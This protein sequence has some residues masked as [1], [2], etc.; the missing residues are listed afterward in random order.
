[1]IM[2]R[3]QT[4][5]SRAP[6]DDAPSRCDEAAFLLRRSV[7]VDSAAPEAADRWSRLS[8]RVQAYNRLEAFIA[9]VTAHGRSSQRAALLARCWPSL[10]LPLT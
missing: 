9:H 1:M 8:D 3:W 5:E 4:L 2:H 7:V 10:T 6:V